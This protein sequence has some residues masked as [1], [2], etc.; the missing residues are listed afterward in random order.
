MAMP[1]LEVDKFTGLNDFNLWRIK[2]KALM[3][4]QGMADA[5]SRERL[6]VMDVNQARTREM[7]L[8][9]HSLIDQA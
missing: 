6:A 1:K 8:K 9:A 4:H 7:L 5:I 3:V 2:M